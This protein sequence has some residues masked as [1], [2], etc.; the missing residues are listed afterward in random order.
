MSVVQKMFNMTMVKIWPYLAWHV[1]VLVYTDFNLVKEY[2]I[3]GR[4]QLMAHKL[5]DVLLDLCSKLLILTYQ[6]LQ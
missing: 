5:L 6:Q 1:E 2:W 4:V 3:K